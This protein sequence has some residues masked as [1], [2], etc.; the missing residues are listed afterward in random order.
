MA[1]LSCECSGELGYSHVRL[2]RRDKY[3]NIYVEMELDVG[4]EFS[5]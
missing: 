3:S 1:C 5:I 4:T 2:D